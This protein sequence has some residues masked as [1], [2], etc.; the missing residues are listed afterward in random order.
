MH[1]S[2]K[3]LQNAVTEE[4][5]IKSENQS[6]WHWTAGVY[7]SHQWTK[8]DAPVFFDEGITQPI[9]NGIQK[10]MYNSIL[11]AMAKQFEA[12]GIPQQQAEVWE[13]PEVVK[14]AKEELLEAT[15]GEYVSPIPD[16]VEPGDGM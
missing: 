10:S 4:I 14:T 6:R 16:G 13:N 2:Q 1:L 15:G 12:K 9:A 3:Q 8:T 5:S 11:S 7:A